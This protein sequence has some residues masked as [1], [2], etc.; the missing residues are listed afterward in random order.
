MES[1]SYKIR[2]HGW[3]LIHLGLAP[4][5]IDGYEGVGEWGKIPRIP[6]IPNFPYKNFTEEELVQREV[7]GWHQIGI[8]SSIVTYLNY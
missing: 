6:Y 7:L 2:N 8:R 3:H 5:F 1:T 4:F